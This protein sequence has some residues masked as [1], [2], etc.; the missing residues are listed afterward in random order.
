[1][2][3]IAALVGMGI[4]SANVIGE[5]NKFVPEKIFE[6]AF[7]EPVSRAV[8]LVGTKDD[9]RQYD[10]RLHFK[11]PHE[12]KPK[13]EAEY[14]DAWYMEARNWFNEAYP[15]EKALQEMD[16]LKFKQRQ[17]NDATLVT[18]EWILYNKH[19]DDVYYRIFGTSR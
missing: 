6:A 5:R 13:N 7:D 15:N 19:T 17:K 18:N 8:E 2:L 16:F 14:K 1:M 9:N 10:V 12:P 11:Y 4:Y 3:A